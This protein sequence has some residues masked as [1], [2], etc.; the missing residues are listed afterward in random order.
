VQNSVEGIATIEP[1]TVVNA[2]VVC[3][4]FTFGT[5]EP[6][7]CVATKSVETQPSAVTLR[8]CSPTGGCTFGDP[9]VTTTLR[10]TGKPQGATF[11]DLPQAEHNVTVLNGTPGL[12]NLRVTVNGKHFQLAGLK[13]GQKVTLDVSS[14]MT[15][16]TGNS[17][18]LT[19][20][21]APGGSATVL[22]SD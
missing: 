18:T 12:K 21:G 11:S 6:V 1:T 13:D 4:A 10:H 5:R 22:I 15:P 17:I 14:A 2:T 9:V 16:G 20:L 3:N 19:P 8:A 7:L